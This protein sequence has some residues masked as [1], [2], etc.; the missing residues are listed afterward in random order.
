MEKKDAALHLY[1][2]NVSQAD[3]A[4]M[5]KVSEVTVSNW[6]NKG[7]WK[8]KRS[9]KAIS[10]ILIHE[11]LVEMLEYH[12]ELESKKIKDNRESGTYEPLDK[13]SINTISK[14][15]SQIKS[16]ELQ[17]DQMVKLLRQFIVY[18][19]TVDLTLAKGVIEHTN[20]FIND[21][22]KSMT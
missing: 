2:E 13:E 21:R 18:I 20:D 7:D 15:Y 9:K 16:K 17:F 6:A 10:E 14:L 4:K 1:V 19:E 5:L 22:R 8:A 12:M 3:I 11:R